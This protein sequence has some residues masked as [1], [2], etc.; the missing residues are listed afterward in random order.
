[1]NKISEKELLDQ[2]P[3]D[4]RADYEAKLKEQVRQMK[5]PV[6]LVQYPDVTTSTCVSQ[7]VHIG[8]EL[9]LGAI[10]IHR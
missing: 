6:I 1:M 8:Y 7:G 5:E 4:V 3:E 2:M 9:N 10:P